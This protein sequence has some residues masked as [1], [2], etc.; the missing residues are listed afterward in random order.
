MTDEKDPA[1]SASDD[2]SRVL[3]Q[4]AGQL[5]AHS[6]QIRW[7][8]LYDYLMAS[9]I[10]LLAWATVFAAN[11][12]GRARAFILLILA[13]GGTV[14]SF[15]WTAFVLRDSTFVNMF[16]QV[17]VKAEESLPSFRS[18]KGGAVGGPFACN[19]AHRVGNT[20]PKHLRWASSRVVVSLV[21]GT[22]TVIY[23]ALAALSGRWLWRS[24][25]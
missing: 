19:V 20:I 4:V 17:G 7:S 2:D 9:T 16:E 24:L 12:P 21:C 11:A 18:Q 5:W 3:Y 6:E 10:L 8:L 25:S 15:V 1:L 22:F 14:V 13:A 23:V